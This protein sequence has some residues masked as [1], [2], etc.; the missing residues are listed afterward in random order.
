[1]AALPHLVL[2]HIAGVGGGRHTRGPPAHRSYSA[3]IA[4]KY[5][6]FGHPLGE[7]D[8]RKSP[9]QALGAAQGHLG[10]NL[11]WLRSTERGL[12]PTRPVVGPGQGHPADSIDCAPWGGLWPQE[13]QPGVLGSLGIRAGTPLV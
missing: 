8:L 3:A 13:A 2:P 12:D 7:T 10:T 1:M 11:G 6:L 5:L 9:I 4:H